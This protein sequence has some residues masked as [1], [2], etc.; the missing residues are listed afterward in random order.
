MSKY[1]MRQLDV[2]PD[3]RKRMH[4]ASRQQWNIVELLYLV[5]APM[6]T[7]RGKWREQRAVRSLIRRDVVEAGFMIGRH[8]VEIK[9]T[10]NMRA[11]LQRYEVAKAAGIFA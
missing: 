4:S 11:A 8:I 10:G 6:M 3:L 9:F 1:Q 2:I 7:L 5:G